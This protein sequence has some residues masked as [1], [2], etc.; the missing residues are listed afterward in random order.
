[1]YNLAGEL[2]FL[3]TVDVYVGRLGWDLQSPNGFPI[4]DGVYIWDVRVR[5]DQNRL[6]EHII[7][8]VVILRQP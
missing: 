3:K 8:K 2:V 7:R 5:D 1:V 6:V 4:A